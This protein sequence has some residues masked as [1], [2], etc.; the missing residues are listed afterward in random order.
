MSQMQ[1]TPASESVI[2]SARSDL[3]RLLG[4][5][6]KPKLE[7]A[8]EFAARLQPETLSAFTTLEQ[9][10][11]MADGIDQLR[12]LLDDKFMGRYV[13]PLMGSSLGFRTDDR[14][15][16]VA[17]VRECVIVALLQGFRWIGNE[18]NIISGR[19][20]FTKEGLARRVREWPGLTNL[21]LEQGTIR[22]GSDGSGMVV[23][24]TMSWCMNGTPVKTARDIPV[25]LNKGQGADA[26]LGKATRKALA[27]VFGMLTG[28]EFSVAEGEVDEPAA[29]AAEPAAQG[30]AA[31]VQK[32]QEAA[33][34][35]KPQ[36]PTPTPPTPQTAP[37]PQREPIATASPSTTTPSGRRPPLFEGEAP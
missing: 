21:M 13:M 18:F 12:K 2:A 10:V 28:S 26:G 34:A 30:L 35:A 24:F 1:H 7:R 17:D 22:W 8:S 20:Y 29:P 9:T 31:A 6:F 11:L 15:Y 23:P 5:E 33:A 37:T 4:Q 3:D 36:T 25:R 14:P 27:T 19:T 16:N 32:A